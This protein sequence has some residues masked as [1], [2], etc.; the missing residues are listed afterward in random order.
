MPWRIT[1]TIVWGG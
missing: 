1:A